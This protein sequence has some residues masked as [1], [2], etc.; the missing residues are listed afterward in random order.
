MAHAHAGYT[1]FF[2]VPR[3]GRDSMNFQRSS[4]ALAAIALLAAAPA[5]V[6][7]AQAAPTASFQAP[8]AGAT[9]SQTTACEVTGER[10]QRVVF[11][12]RPYDG[13]TW[14]TLTTDQSAPWRCRID[15]SRFAN[16][17]DWLRAI[18]YD[19]DSGGA[20]DTI[21]RAITISKSNTA[22]KV[23]FKTPG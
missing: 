12:I 2:Q 13:G 14:T 1:K 11:S 15:P 3:K 6:P 21:T 18:A 7:S 5:V 8:A 20:S 17:Q 4:I 22:P 10:I 9:I 19:R 23:S 16:G